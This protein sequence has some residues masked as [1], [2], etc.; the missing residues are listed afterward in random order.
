MVTCCAL[1]D[2]G[3][4]LG[5]TPLTEGVPPVTVKLPALDRPDEMIEADQQDPAAAGRYSKILPVHR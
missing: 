5:D 4:G 3:T 2:P 1:F